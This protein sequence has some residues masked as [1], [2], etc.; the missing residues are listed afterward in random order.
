[1]AN[2][3]TN[4]AIVR[5]S[6]R[7]KGVVVLPLKEYSAIQKRVEKLAGEAKALQIIAEG[8]REY[9]EGKLKQTK[10]LKSLLK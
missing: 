4:T 3:I 2:G 9:R 10:S 1:M 5:E 7:E 6:F 8:E